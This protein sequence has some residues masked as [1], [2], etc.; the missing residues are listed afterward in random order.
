MEARDNLS[1]E[2][3][4]KAYLFKIAKNLFINSLTRNQK[5]YSLH[6][7]FI[8]KTLEV[9]QINEDMLEYDLRKAVLK[10]PEKCRLIFILNR[11]HNFKYAEIAE[12][13]DI[14]LQTVKN[15]MT[16]AIQIIKEYLNS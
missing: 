14:S 9:D 11:F 7:E 15:H 10:I 13:L 8:H 3:Y 5:L 16:K 4:P 6:E 12:I 1:I 2:S